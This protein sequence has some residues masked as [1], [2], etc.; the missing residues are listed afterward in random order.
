MPLIVDRER[1]RLAARRF[2][3]LVMPGGVAPQIERMFFANMRYVEN[4]AITGPTGDASRRWMVRG[5]CVS[6]NSPPFRR[7]TERMRA[8]PVPSFCR[9]SSSCATETP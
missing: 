3:G 9:A 5:R 4:R 1:V 8:P 2:R 6:G 7:H